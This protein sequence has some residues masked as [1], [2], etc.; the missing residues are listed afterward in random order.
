MKPYVTFLA[1]MG[2]GAALALFAVGGIF[3]WWLGT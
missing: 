3:W 2:V 1:G